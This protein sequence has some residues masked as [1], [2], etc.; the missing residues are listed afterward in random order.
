MSIPFRDWQIWQYQLAKEKTRWY[1]PV[2][3]T[4][5]Q[6]LE[7]LYCFFRSQAF[8]GSGFFVAFLGC[9]KCRNTSFSI[10][11]RYHDI[12]PY[13]GR[14]AHLSA[15]PWPSLQAAASLPASASIH[16]YLSPFNT[17]P[18]IRFCNSDAMVLITDPDTT[19]MLP[20]PLF[21]S[22]HY[23]PLSSMGKWAIFQLLFFSFF[24]HFLKLCMKSTSFF[25]IFFPFYFLKKSDL[26]FVHLQHHINSL[27]I[28][29]F[30]FT[31]AYILSIGKS[32]KSPPLIVLLRRIT[33]EFESF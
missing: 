8:M 15:L 29:N 32:F 20:F 25:F 17:S 1:N 28:I 13:Y 24:S 14:S 19:H 16:I 22:W 5:L 23:L 10:E 4:K 6:Q 31:I 7:Q 11:S 18:L 3:E 27:P 2:V 26:F 12:F 21:S 30:S 9:R 33:K